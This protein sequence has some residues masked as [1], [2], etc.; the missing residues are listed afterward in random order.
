MSNMNLSMPLPRTSSGRVYRFS[1]NEVAHP[2]HFVL[3]D[4]L[5]DV[6]LTA[7]T[8]ARMKQA[9][10]SN[11]TVCPY[12][13]TVAAD[14]AYVHPDDAKAALEMVKHDAIQDAE[15][16]VAQMLVPR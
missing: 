1:P 5:A 15:D 10:R 9:P 11:Q 16:A 4:V 14:A 13:G 12:S 7:A 3:G 8:R 2:R 6:P